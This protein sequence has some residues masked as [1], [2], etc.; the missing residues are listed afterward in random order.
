MVRL[1]DGHDQPDARRGSSRPALGA[2]GIVVAVPRLGVD[3]P[4][5]VGP[6]EVLVDGR[7]ARAGQELLL[8]DDVESSVVRCTTARPTPTA[9]SRTSSTTWRRCGRLAAAAA[10]CCRPRVAARSARRWSASEL[11]RLLVVADGAPSARRLGAGEQR[12]HLGVGRGAGSAPAVAAGQHRDLEVVGDERAVGT[13]QRGDRGVRARRPA[14]RPSRPA[15]PE[16]AAA[17]ASA[18]PP[19]TLKRCSSI[20]VPS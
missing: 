9:T 18:S 13:G 8:A 10:P 11:V 14:S 6:V 4:L 17:M 7:R 3:G 19:S 2:E 16:R 15:P 12:G 20:T 5:A 1:V